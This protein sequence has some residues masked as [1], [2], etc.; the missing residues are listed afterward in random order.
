MD[1]LQ[2]EI[3]WKFDGQTYIETKNKPGAIVI[4]LA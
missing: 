2:I 1:S 4:G 3:N